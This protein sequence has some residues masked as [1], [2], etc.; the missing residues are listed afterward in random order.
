MCREGLRLLRERGLAAPELAEL[1]REILHRRLPVGPAVAHQPKLARPS[2]LPPDPPH[3]VGRADEAGHRPSPARRAPPATGDGAGLGPGRGGEDVLRAAPGAPRRRRLSGRAAATSTC[4]ASTPPGWRWIRARRSRVFLDALAVPPSR[5]PATVEA[6]AALYRSAC[7]PGRR[8]L[9]VLDNVDGRRAGPSAAAR[10]AGL[11]RDRGQPQP[12]ARP[13]RRGRRPAGPGPTC[14]TAGEARRLLARRLGADRLAGRG[15][16]RPTT[17]STRCARL[18]AGVGGRGGPGRHPPGL[19]AR[20]ARRRAARGPG[21]TGSRRL[22]PRRHGP[23]TSEAVLSWSRRGLT[24]AADRLFRLL[25]LHG[26]SGPRAPRPWP[27]SPAGAS[28]RCGRRCAELATRAPASPN[29]SAR[30]VRPATTCSGAYADRTGAAGPAVTD[31]RGRP[32]VASSTTTCTPPSAPTGCCG[33]TA[34]RRRR[35]RRRRG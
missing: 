8:V 10:R 29:T 15:Q 19:S 16:R 12:T 30:P 14:S 35:R 27:A 32:A 31:R 18:P 24:E 3:F 4:A 34:I 17:S 33:R 20:I 22:R 23:R 25:G 5:I 26:R 7:S 9:V 6:Q 28:T 11:R 1:H 2:L 21:R 13:G